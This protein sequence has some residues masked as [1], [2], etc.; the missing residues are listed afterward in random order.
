MPNETDER[1]E[2]LEVL[3]YLAF[4]IL[5]ASFEHTRKSSRTENSVPLCSIYLNLNIRRS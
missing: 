2:S 3:H 4:I 1:V 5:L